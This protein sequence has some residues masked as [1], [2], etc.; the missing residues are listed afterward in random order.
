MTKLV[1]LRVRV[2]VD[3]AVQ[4]DAA[5]SELSKILRGKGIQVLSAPE[6]KPGE[7]TS[8]SGEDASIFWPTADVLRS[9]RAAGRKGRGATDG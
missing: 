4:V 7:Q 2:A 1:E 8:L 6:P 5:K 9:D 3:D